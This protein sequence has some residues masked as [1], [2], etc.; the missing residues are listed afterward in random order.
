LAAHEQH[1]GER[2][3]T[4]SVRKFLKVLGSPRLAAALINAQ[5]QFRGK[6]KAPLSVRLRGRIIISGDGQVEFGN[7]VSLV[8]DVVPIEI[9]CH[10]GAR[11][12]IGDDT[13]V[14]YGSL[15]SAY[16]HIEIGH[17]C[18]LGHYLTLLDN[19]EHDVEQLEVPAPSAPIVIGDHVWIGSRVIILPGVS[20]GHGAAVGAG[21]VVTKSIP[22]RCLAVGNP[23]RVL[24]ELPAN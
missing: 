21:S 2:P 12:S 11:V 14:N 6:A 22:P 20:I 3:S 8:G 9:V 24:R 4:V 15:I 23:A 18:L 10:K 13:F 16:K 5:V 1:D 17:H 19:N 7:G